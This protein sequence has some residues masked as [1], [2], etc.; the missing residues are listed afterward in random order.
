MRFE[1]IITAVTRSLAIAQ[2]REITVVESF[3]VAIRLHLWLLRT[4]LGMPSYPRFDLKQSQDAGRINFG[5]LGCKRGRGQS[6][7]VLVTA[8]CPAGFAS[9]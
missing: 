8:S 9:A 1:Q 4:T 5:R 6:Q 3:A 7:L 2:V